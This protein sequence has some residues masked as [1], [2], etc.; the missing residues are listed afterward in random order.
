MERIKFWVYLCFL[1]PSLVCS[2]FLLSYLLSNRTLRTALHNHAIIVFLLIG[3]FYQA[4]LYPWMLYYYNYEGIWHRSSLFCTIWAFIDW[5][6]Y[7]T[8]M[9]LFAWASMERHILIFHHNWLST[10]QKRLFVHYLPLVMLLLYCLVYYIL[11]IFF[12]PCKNTFDVS[13]MTCVVLCYLFQS[14]ALYTYDTLVHQVLPNLIIVIF[15]IALL[16]RVHWQKKRVGKSLQWRKHWKMTGQM[17]FIS[18]IYLLFALPITLMNFLHLCGLS[19][20]VSAQLMDYLFVFNYC[21]ILLWPFACAWSLPQL[22]YKLKNVFNFRRQTR[23]VGPITLYAGKI[24][25]LQ[26]LSS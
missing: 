19:R 3:L 24:I 11:T 4:T 22:K 25:L 20:N 23:A 7:Y 5:G 12:P 15:S 21:M 26:T 14:F 13:Q 16:L 6:L 8:Q 10:R 9:I 1:I 17:L 2:V 18:T